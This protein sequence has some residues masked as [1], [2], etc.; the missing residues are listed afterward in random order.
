MI[1]H[2][3]VKNEQTKFI[4]QT[5]HYHFWNWLQT[6]R[7]EFVSEILVLFY[8]DWMINIISKHMRCACVC[9][10]TKLSLLYVRQKN[11]GLAVRVK[12]LILISQW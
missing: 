8:K 4:F 5:I 7:R 11:G 10:W 12:S 1:T 2:S 6:V 3:F 9:V